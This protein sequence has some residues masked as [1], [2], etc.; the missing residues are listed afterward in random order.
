M[1][2]PWFDRMQYG[3]THVHRAIPRVEVTARLT[4]FS[5]AFNDSL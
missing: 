1:E 5:I 4:R 3:I 2:G